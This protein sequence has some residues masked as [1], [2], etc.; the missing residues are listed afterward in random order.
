MTASRASAGAM[1]ALSLAAPLRVAHAQWASTAR[2]VFARDVAA[3]GGSRQSSRGD[4][5]LPVEM[6]A[7]VAGSLAGIAIVG[8]SADCGV[9]DLA[10]IIQA[11]AGGGALGAAGATVA[12]VVAARMTG[13]SYS[14]AGAGLGALA[15][16]AG[17]LG[18]HWLL[19]R[20][21]D[22]NLGDRIVIPI[23]AV[24]QG[25]GAALGSR[26]LGGR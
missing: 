15:G 9:D 23:F 21:T 13:G 5:S 25:V 26:L 10:C 16:T 11:V 19:N 24:A 2:V 22:R 18:V 6:L 4:G 17:G 7:G 20:G 14:W 12:V 3:H 8:L 1:L